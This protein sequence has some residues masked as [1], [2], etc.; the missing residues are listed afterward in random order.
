MCV[1]YNFSP[2]LPNG[3]YTDKNDYQIF[4]I[5]KE[6]QNGAVAKLYMKKGLLI[7]EEMRKYFLIYEEAHSHIWFCN[8]SILNFLIY[9]ENLI[10]FFYLCRNKST[11]HFHVIKPEIMQT[12]FTKLTQI[13]PCRTYIIYEGKEPDQPILNYLPLT[14]PDKGGI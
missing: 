14:L 4:L 5:Y 6:I 1:I 10:F 9:E 13:R 3:A 2:T 11:L 8:C 12:I 7:Y